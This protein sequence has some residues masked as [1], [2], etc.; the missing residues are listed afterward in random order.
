MGEQ[1]VKIKRKLYFKKNKKEK[2][3]NNSNN[4]KTKWNK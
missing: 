2:E 1:Y 4:V 3:N